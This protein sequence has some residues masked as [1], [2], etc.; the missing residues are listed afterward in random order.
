MS[1]VAM[2]SLIGGF[3][4]ILTLFAIQAKLVNVQDDNG[5]HDDGYTKF[6]FNK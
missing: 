5:L 4:T 2:I 3:I 1:L 6:V